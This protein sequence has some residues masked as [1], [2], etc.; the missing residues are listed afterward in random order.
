[1]KEQWVTAWIEAVG[2]KA[3]HTVATMAK[4]KKKAGAAADVPVMPSKQPRRSRKIL[5][6]KSQSL[7]G[8]TELTAAGV[9]ASYP[10]YPAPSNTNSLPL[11]TTILHTLASEVKYNNSLIKISIY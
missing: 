3:A 11:G 6:S 2:V 4:G 5:V 7:V 9:T 10:A 1:V 8:D